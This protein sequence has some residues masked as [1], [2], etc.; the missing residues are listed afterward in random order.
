MRGRGDGERDLSAR[1]TFIYDGV[2]DPEQCLTCAVFMF[3]ETPNMLSVAITQVC[4]VTG[5]C[6]GGD[7]DRSGQGGGKNGRLK[8]RSSEPLS[9]EAVTAETL[10]ISRVSHP[11][12][13]RPG[14]PQSNDLACAVEHELLYERRHEEEL[15]RRQQSG[16]H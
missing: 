16:R 8:L 15:L 1:R 14:T 11:H 5:T 9:F 6:A 13:R 10:S 3:D 12:P 2:P 7:R 4:T